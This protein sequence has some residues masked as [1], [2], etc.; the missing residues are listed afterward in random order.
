MIFSDPSGSVA[1]ANIKSAWKYMSIKMEEKK[2]ERKLVG[3]KK[4]N[5]KKNK[6][7]QS[8]ADFGKVRK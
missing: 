2:K 3:K 5:G 4:E 7:R 1:S 6:N 8:K